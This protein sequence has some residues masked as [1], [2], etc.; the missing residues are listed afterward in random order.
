MNLDKLNG[1]L[2]LAA[3]LGVLAGI[4]FLA[5]ELDQSNRQARSD[6]FQARINEI[7]HQ[8]REFALSDSLPSI[9][10]KLEESGVDSLTP[11]ELLRVS[12]WES[13]RMARMHG[14]L[15]QYKNGFLDEASYR[16]LLQVGPRAL[17]LWKELGKLENSV[18]D[19]LI[20]TL[21]QAKE[22]RGT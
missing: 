10:A 22:E 2:T 5:I 3:N 7:D 1:W 11:E 6:A 12:Q 9:Y 21:Q 17:P 18:F 13:A 4:V 8:G 19:E 14:Q 16:Q 15:V 20:K